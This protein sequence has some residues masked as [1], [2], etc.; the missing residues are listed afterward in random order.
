MKADE[1]Q[2]L[3]DD[4]S[5]LQSDKQQQPFLNR[6]QQPNKYRQLSLQWQLQL[7]NDRPVVSFVG[8]C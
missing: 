8:T 7:Y 5:A 4:N 3:F 1:H 2:V 6:Q